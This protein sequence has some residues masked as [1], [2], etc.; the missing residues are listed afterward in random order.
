MLVAGVGQIVP[1]PLHRDHHPRS[2]SLIL[3]LFHR[4]GEADGAHD[5]VAKLLV[6]DCLVGVAV[7]LHNLVQSIYEGLDWGH[8]PGPAPIWEAR[9]GERGRVLAREVE[10]LGQALDILGGRCS[11]PVEQPRDSNF[12]STEVVGNGLK[13][14][15]LGSLGVE[16]GLGVGGQ[17]RLKSRLERIERKRSAAVTSPTNGGLVPVP[18]SRCKGHAGTLSW[19]DKDTRLD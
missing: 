1:F 8:G 19:R 5:A 18:S 13:R 11:L 3:L 12:A 14:E 6:H 2:A 17:S 16:E 4:R 9:A 10:E 7:V 15:P